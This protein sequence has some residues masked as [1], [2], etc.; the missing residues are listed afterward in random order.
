M[1][2]KR[3][4]VF[5]DATDAAQ[6]ALLRGLRFEHDN[7]PGPV[8]RFLD[9]GCADGLLVL[10]I[11]GSTSFAVGMDISLDELR[12]ARQRQQAGGQSNVAFVV[13]D[14]LHP[15]F[16]DG[17]FD[18]VVARFALHHTDLQTSLPEMRRLVRGGGRLLL[19][20][21][22]ARFPSMQRYRWW[23]YPSILAKAVG[24]TLGA[25]VGAGYRYARHL[26]RPESMQ[27][28]TQANRL[29]S[30]RHYRRVHRHHLPGCRF[31]RSG[32]AILYGTAPAV[33]WDAP[34]T[35]DPK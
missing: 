28:V 8:E 16:R 6:A 17:V 5:H 11:A 24:R 33:I 26:L 32:G 13:G 35:P 34:P 22:I 7:V 18:Y 30:A 21:V 29:V 9:V 23:H 20:D 15:P 10:A 14:L 3:T 4:L 2:D 31:V 12:Q 25:G 1:S 27:H 19:R